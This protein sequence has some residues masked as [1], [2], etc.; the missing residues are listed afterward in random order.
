MQ[1]YIKYW[2]SAIILVGITIVFGLLLKKERTYLSTSLKA[3]AWLQS[4]SIE[5]DN[6]KV[7]P[8]DPGDPTSISA[9]LYS[10][11]SGVI[12][13]FV[14]LYRT[15]QNKSF[16]QE[17]RSGANY[18]LTTLP[19]T[20]INPWQIGLYN[21]VAGVGFALE[22]TYK[23]TK[24]IKYHEG[25][26]KCLKLL[27]VSA[28][29]V[30]KGAEWNNVTDIMSGSAGIG[31]FLLYSARYMEHKASLNLAIQIGRRLLE[32]AIPEKGGLKW[33]MNPDY[34]RLMPNFSHGTAGI[35]YFLVSLYAA[36]REVDFLNGA[37]AGA[38]YLQKI[39]N[40]QGLI[41]HHEPGGENFFYLGWRHGPAGTARLYYRLWKE[42]DDNKWLHAL[43]RAAT[44]IILS[45]IPDQHTPCFWNNVGQCCGSAGVAEFFLNLHK[46]T[47]R[48][49]YLDFS[50]RVTAD[51]LARATSKGDG[52]KWIQAEYRSKPELLAA[53]TGYMQGAAGIGMCLLHFD[54]FEQGKEPGI[55][56]PDVP[57]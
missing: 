9:D 15:T 35:S 42:T 36:T 7:W 52:L 17:A 37:L 5:T 22:E 24:D 46:V 2:V 32:L 19:D 11:N 14:E 49:N 30:G 27:H 20:L 18:L 48:Q 40:E 28:Q 4:V 26:L 1:Q 57:F 55:V 43:N 41:F 45:G 21:G 29:S 16:L 39:T 25:A 8:A 3:A 34:D 31:L 6:G 13:F 33:R 12:I 50:R 53:Q 56:L 51:L 23:T 44:G 47:G 10:G 38:T 54:A